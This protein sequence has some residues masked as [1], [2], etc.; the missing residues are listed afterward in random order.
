M[1]ITSPSFFF[2]MLFLT[3]KYSGWHWEQQFCCSRCAWSWC[4][5]LLQSRAVSTCP[6]PAV[7]IGGVFCILSPPRKT[8]WSGSSWGCCDIPWEWD[9]GCLVGILALPDAKSCLTPWAA[10]L[11]AAQ[12]S[13]EWASAA[14]IRTGEKRRW[15]QGKNRLQNHTNFCQFLTWTDLQGIKSFNMLCLCLETKMKSR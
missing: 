3:V 5:I 4:H 6:A 14:L 7:E 15:L 8:G 12:L 9:V 11:T 10:P 1:Q 2:F 13:S